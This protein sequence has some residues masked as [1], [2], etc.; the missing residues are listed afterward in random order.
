MVIRRKAA[1][2]G[3]RPAYPAAARSGLFVR[4][5]GGRRF[6]VRFAGGRGRGFLLLGFG[7][8]GGRLLL[9]GVGRRASRRGLGAAGGR[10]HLLLDAFVDEVG[11]LIERQGGM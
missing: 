1:R 6:R 9:F 3:R 2:K 10:L 4:R 11:A 7:S 8:G 5:V